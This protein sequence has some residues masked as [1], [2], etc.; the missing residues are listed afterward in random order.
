M[1]LHTRRWR[2]ISL[3]PSEFNFK[4]IESASGQTSNKN[5]KIKVTHMFTI[6]CCQ[7]EEMS[8]DSV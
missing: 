1:Q 6:L 4:P 8:R 7:E 5:G 3:T 2:A